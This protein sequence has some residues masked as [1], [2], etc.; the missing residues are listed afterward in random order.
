MTVRLRHSLRALRPSTLALACTALLLGSEL[1]PPRAQAEPGSRDPSDQ[2]GKPV[3]RADVGQWGT[4]P[5][6]QTDI[7]WESVLA[8]GEFAQ[9]VW[10]GAE[11]LLGTGL[12]HWETLAGQPKRV[13]SSDANSPAELQLAAGAAVRQPVAAYVPL[14]RAFRLTGRVRG[15]AEVVLVEDSGTRTRFKVPGGLVE[16][17]LEIDGQAWAKRLGRDPLPRFEVELHGGSEGA[18]FHSLAVHVGLPQA[19]PDAMRAE[20]VATLDAIVR[21]W[22]ERGLDDYGSRSSTFCTQRF[23]VVTGAPVDRPSHGSVH[24]LFETLLEATT[25]EPQPAWTALLE[26]HIDDLLELGIHPDTGL[27]RLWEAEQDAPLDRRPVEIARTLR[28]LLSVAERG[29]QNQREACLA[30]AK[31]MGEAVLEYG[32]L[33]TGEVAATYRPEDGQPTAAVSRLRRLDV[34]AELVR[35]S[36]M[37]GDERFSDAAR[38][39]LSAFEFLHLWA[40][41]WNSIDPGFDDDFGHFGARSAT[42]GLAAPDEPY[43]ARLGFTGADYYLPRWKQAVTHGG[44]V[45]ADQ[46]RS[47]RVLADLARLDRARLPE[48]GQALD[49]ALRAHFTG[50][51]TADGSWVD[52]S[53]HRFD[54]KLKLEVGDLPGPP[55][56]LLRGLALCGRPELGFEQ[57]R[58]DALFLAVLRSTIDTYGRPYGLLPTLPESQGANPSGASL[59]IASELAEWLLHR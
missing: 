48:V 40:G 6:A 43:F 25:V 51:Q 37:T 9:P 14:A 15:S 16:R 38:R 12:P 36:A 4:Y 10:P 53:H 59:R 31:R 29:P 32:L 27:P 13:T 55:A 2:Q 42:M 45:A 17:P 56:N 35:L 5:R 28:F 8:G 20:V 49:L 46:T 19:E 7:R 24:V 30:A 18:A 50:E 54:P 57:D 58:L 1:S 22:S 47:W 26:A 21:Q 44:F 33:P 39:A 52:V 3:G 11:G 41:S 34:P 23:D